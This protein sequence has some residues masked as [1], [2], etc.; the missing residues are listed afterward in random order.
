[1]WVPEL[2]SLW[3]LLHR[4]SLCSTFTECRKSVFF[5]KLEKK[6]VCCI[7]SYGLSSVAW[8]CWSKHTHSWLLGL[9]GC[10]AEMVCLCALTAV[11]CYLKEFPQHAPGLRGHVFVLPGRPYCLAWMVLTPALIT[12]CFA[13][14]LDDIV[15]IQAFIRANKARDDYK[16]LSE[17]HRPFLS[18]HIAKVQG[19]QLDISITSSMLFKSFCGLGCITSSHV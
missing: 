8:L 13:S 19:L 6:H 2:Y 4:S 12:V 10:S 17:Y 15:K 11:S 3:I 9:G 1:M 16:T 18:P 5:P 14:Q 7:Q